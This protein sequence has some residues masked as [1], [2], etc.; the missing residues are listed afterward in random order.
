[1][2]RPGPIAAEATPRVS[3][4]FSQCAPQSRQAA[5]GQT[6]VTAAGRPSRSLDQV[7]PCSNATSGGLRT[8]TIAAK[9]R[10]SAVSHSRAI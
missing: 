10:H 8:S 7:G 5:S 1:M 9:R 4:C 2:S 6:E 3:V